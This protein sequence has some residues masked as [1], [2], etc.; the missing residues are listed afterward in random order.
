MQNLRKARNLGAPG[1][2]LPHATVAR[3]RDGANVDPEHR[4]W[5][6]LDSDGCIDA[7]VDRG[8][9]GGLWREESF[10][11]HDLHAIAVGSFIKNGSNYP[12][13]RA[14]DCFTNS[15][16]VHSASLFTTFVIAAAAAAFCAAF[17]A[18]CLCTRSA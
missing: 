3:G 11:P 4:D 15:S 5:R 6:V 7:S 1:S 10:L 13:E 16:P 12:F 9:L 8:D 17:L 2:K 14:S 18:A